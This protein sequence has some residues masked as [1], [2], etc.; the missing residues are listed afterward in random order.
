VF[1]FGWEHIDAKLIDQRFLRRGDYNVQTP[2]S[3]Q[4]WEYLVEF[5]DTDGK[6]VRLPIEE[7]TFKL[8]LPDIGGTVPIRVNKRRTKAAFDLKDPRIDATGARKR[9]EKARE[10]RDKARFEARL[11][12]IDPPEGKES[13]SSSDE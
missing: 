1:R 9:A 8:R 2:G 4:V 5:I 6:T 7:K 3:Y 10:E 13:D 11:K 12:G